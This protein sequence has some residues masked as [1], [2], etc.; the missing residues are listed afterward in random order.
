MAQV[1]KLYQHFAP[2]ERLTLTLEAMARGDTDEAM[3]L[4]HTCPVRLYEFP[5]QAFDRPREFI[6]ELAV[7]VAGDLGTMNA[8]LS[9]FASFG[10]M[11]PYLTSPHAMAAEFSFM[12][13]WRLGKGL[14]PLPAPPMEVGDEEGDYIDVEQF[15]EDARK[16]TGV[17]V[18]ADP[19]TE[20]ADWAPTPEQKAELDAW[21]APKEWVE[22]ANRRLAG[23]YRPIVRR[24]VREM[25]GVWAA[26]DGFC[27]AKVG[28]DGDTG[29]RAHSPGTAQR[30]K[31]IGAEHP[32]LTPWEERREQCAADFEACWRK[33]FG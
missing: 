28:V 29:M 9:I 2:A 4:R 20:R 19:A 31:E 26:W 5:D 15:L 10:E 3:R 14:S 23:L 1:D 27:Q 7:I 24:V 22:L 13:G 16:G 11:A 18:F 21:D 6:W 30:M 17:S 32:D 12:A 8:K 25:L 33:R